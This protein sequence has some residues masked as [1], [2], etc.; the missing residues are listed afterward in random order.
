LVTLEAFCRTNRIKN[1]DLL[2]MDIEG[3]EYL[4]IQKS[5]DFI[6]KSVYSLFIEFHNLSPSNSLLWI[7]EYFKRNGFKVEEIIMN[8]TLVI[9]NTN[10]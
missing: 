10:I 5:I 2:K 9:K 7:I 6:K 3:C 4:V 8:R 1:I